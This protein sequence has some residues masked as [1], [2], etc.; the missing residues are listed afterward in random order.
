MAGRSKA[1]EE[2]FKQISSWIVEALIRLLDEKSYRAISVEDITKKAGV[3]RST[4]Y[5]HFS[6][7]DDVILRFLD[8]CFNPTPL[9]AKNIQ[10][11]AEG[12]ILYFT[13]SLKQL[14][15]CAKALKTIL[16]SDAEYL[17]FMYCKKWIDYAINLY[18]EKLKGDEKIAFRYMVQFTN[19]GAA[20]VLCDWIK[21]DMP[22]PIKKLSEWLTHPNYPTHN[23]TN[24]IP[25]IVLRVN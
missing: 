10:N 23:F 5:R 17:V 4:F 9:V 25:H 3:A 11:D 14:L 20:Q 1:H 15:R 16:I 13:L 22:I 12:D 8:V 7:K 18:D 21:N 19:T 6:S 24:P 2:Q